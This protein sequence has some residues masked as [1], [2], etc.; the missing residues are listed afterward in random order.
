MPA[1][2][3]HKRV[4]DHDQGPNTGG[5]GAYSPAPVLTPAVAEKTM[6]K[7]VRPT[8]MAL[9]ARGTPYMGILYAGLMIKDGEPKLI[10]YNCRFGDPE[11][12]VILPRLKSDL[13]AAYLAAHDG[14]LD[15]VTLDW[16]DGATLTVVVAARGYPGPYPKGSVIGGLDKAGALEDVTVFHAGTAAKD[17]HIVA[18]GGRVLN[19]TATGATV[20]AAAA[21]AYA[22]VDALDWPEGVC[23]RDI[24]WRAIKRETGK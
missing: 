22:A 6:A 3:D 17:G 7:I 9:A 24:G 12:Q 2:R 16:R 1:A 14:T 4:F 10:E 23:R 13:L 11:T 18:N 8:I 15:Q 19:V 5:M 20:A 21:K